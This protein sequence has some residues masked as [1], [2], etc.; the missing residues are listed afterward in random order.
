MLNF[1][2]RSTVLALFFLSILS[3]QNYTIFPLLLYKIVSSTA[4]KVPPLLGFI[5]SARFEQNSGVHA[6]W[7]HW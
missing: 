7:Q 2:I 4:I 6:I 3:K 1:R 5:F